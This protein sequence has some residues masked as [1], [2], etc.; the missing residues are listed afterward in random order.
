M[1]VRWLDEIK[2]FCFNVTHLPKAQNP[3][4]LLILRGFAD[5]QEQATSTGD[6][7]PERQQE[8][9]FLVWVGM[10]RPQWSSQLFAQGQQ[11]IAWWQRPRF[12]KVW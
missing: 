7:D 8:L 5:R 10:C 1:Y 6:L 4:D 12:A 11:R 3:S 9:F 2:D